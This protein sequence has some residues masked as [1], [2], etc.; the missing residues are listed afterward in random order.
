MFKKKWVR[1]AI[2]VQDGDEISILQGCTRATQKVGEDAAQV[3]PRSTHTLTV[4]SLSIDP[5]AII[6]C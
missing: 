4:K 5:E 1:R 6:F 2:D 3:D